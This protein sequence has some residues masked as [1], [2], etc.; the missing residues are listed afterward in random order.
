VSLKLAT[1]RVVRLEN[2]FLGLRPFSHSGDGRGSRGMPVARFAKVVAAGCSCRL[3]RERDKVR[4]VTWPRQRRESVAIEFVSPDGS[5]F[6]TTSEGG[7]RTQGGCCLP[8][9]R[10]SAVCECGKADGRADGPIQGGL[11]GLPFG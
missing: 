9:T 5:C 10:L 11:C 6:R 7:P 4:V 3:A 2:K 8:P 1:P